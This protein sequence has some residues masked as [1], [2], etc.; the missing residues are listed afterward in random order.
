MG[1]GGKGKFRGKGGKGFGG[2]VFEH[3]GPIT[4]PPPLYPPDKMR[5]LLPAEYPISREDSGLISG[6]RRLLHFWKTSPYYIRGREFGALTSREQEDP[7]QQMWQIT[8]GGGVSPNY[9]PA[10][11]LLKSQLKGRGRG[12]AQSVLDVFRRM[13]GKEKEKDGKGKG[14]DGE[15]ANPRDADGDGAGLDDAADNDEHDDDY[16]DEDYVGIHDDFEDGMGNDFDDND[17]GGGGGE[18][19]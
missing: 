12:T 2:D 1:F 19:M 3:R 16:G 5:R 6:H 7:E 17:G 8:H 13:E 10:E 9:F 18:E 14:K 11:L 4:E 15:Q